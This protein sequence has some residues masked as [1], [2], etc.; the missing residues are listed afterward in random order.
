MTSDDKTETSATGGPK[1]KREKV[2]LKQPHQHGGELHP[3][4]A[5][6]AVTA[7]Q[8]KRLADRDKI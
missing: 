1:A 5:Q 6:I 7:A 8:K 3:A 2:T 4:G